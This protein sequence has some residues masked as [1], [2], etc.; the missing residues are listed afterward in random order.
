[1]IKLRGYQPEDKNFI[2]DSYLRNYYSSMTGYKPESSVFF[3]GQQRL[4]EKLIENDNAVFVIAC[5]SDEPDIIF[6]WSLFS[7][8]K[9]LHYVFVKEAYRRM[10]LS[11]KMLRHVLKEKTDLVVS[12]WNKDCAILRRKFKL[13]Y[14]PYKFYQ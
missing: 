10:G 5:S 9:T 2:F 3:P 13:V 1:M 11:S 14:N 8:D 6:G 4:L 12:H 7:M